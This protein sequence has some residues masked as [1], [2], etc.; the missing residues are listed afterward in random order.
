MHFLHSL[1]VVASLGAAA[2]SFSADVRITGTF[3]NLRYNS[4]SGDLQVLKS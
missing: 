4:E 1:I 2:P 3:S